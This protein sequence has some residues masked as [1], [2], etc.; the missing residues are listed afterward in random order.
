MSTTTRKVTLVQPECGEYCP[1][2]LVEKTLLAHNTFA[3]D[4][5]R[6]RGNKLKEFARTG[7]SS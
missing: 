5:H 1:P 2:E 4:F 7:N 3:R 6:W